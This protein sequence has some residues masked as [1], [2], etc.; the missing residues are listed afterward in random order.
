[1][2]EF[3]KQKED[4][5][6]LDYYFLTVEESDKMT[7]LGVLFIGTQSQRGRLM[8]APV[9]QCIQ[10]DQ[11]GELLNLKNRNEL[12]P[13]L[14]KLVDDCIVETSGSKNRKEYRVNAAVL[15][16][17]D[18]KGTTSLKRIEPYRIR[19]LI[20]EDLKIYECSGAKDMHQRIGIEIPYKKVL[21]QIKAMLSDGIIESE[22]EN[23]WVKYKLKKR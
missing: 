9:V 18:Y 6:L 20:I 7:N 2:S 15:K 16:Q 21:E 23:R 5:E 8:N 19:E 17:S 1:M 22:G 10:F 11:Y 13:W 3:I 14:D 12:S 4:K